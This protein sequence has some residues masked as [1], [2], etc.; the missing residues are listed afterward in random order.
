M[1]VC[2]C[3]CARVR[4]RERKRER[5]VKTTNRIEKKR[6]KKIVDYTK[7]AYC[8]CDRACVHAYVCVCV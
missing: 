4:E 8:S 3:V 6:R 2:V 1:C 7:E 5:N